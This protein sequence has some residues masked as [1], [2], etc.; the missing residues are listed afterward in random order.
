MTN[1]ETR[2][3]FSRAICIILALV[4]LLGIFPIAAP[5]TVVRAVTQSQ[6]NT[7]ARADYLYDITW[8]CQKTVS[9][10]KGK[11]TFYEGQ[12]YRIPYAWPVTAGKWVGYGVSVDEFLSATKDPES[13]FYTKQSYYTGNSGSYAPY[14]GNDCSTF[15]SWCWDLS[16]RQ[17]TQSITSV[18]GVSLLGA[19]TASNVNANLQLGDA[20]N[21]AGSHIVLVTD[22]TY[23]ADGS[24]ASVEITEQ[25]P[26]QLKRTVH[27][28]SSLVSAYGANYKIYRYSGTVSEPPE[29]GAD[30]NYYTVPTADISY[31]ARGD[32]VAWIQAVLKKIGYSLSVDG[33]F[34]SETQNALSLYQSQYGLLVTG[35]AD[36]ATRASLIGWWTDGRGVYKTTANL[37]M[38][39][40]DGTSHSII[41]T[42]PAGTE[43]AVIG[44]NASGSWANIVY[45]SVEGWVN[46][47]Y[48]SFVRKFNYTVNFNT[49]IPETMATESFK[50]GRA[51]SI[52]QPPANP[53]GDHF[54]GW[55]LL[56]LSDLS[57]YDGTGWAAEQ[58]SSKLF[59]AG[60]L[61][62]FDPAMLNGRWGDD[63]FYLCAVWKSVPLPTVSISPSE[64]GITDTG[65]AVFSAEATGEGLTY[66]WSCSDPDFYEYLSGV[67]TKEL[68]VSINEALEE[69]RTL[70]FT[71]TVTDR[72]G[73]RVE[74]DAACL[75]Y[76][77]SPLPEYI[78]GDVNGDCTVSAYDVNL[79]KRYVTGRYA[80]EEGSSTYLA[81]DINGDG[82]ITAT[83]VNLLIRIVAG[84]YVAV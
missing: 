60:E 9:A 65:S 46:L 23:N 24:L 28:V 75:F 52:P 82:V 27:T 64:L 42:I 10:W 71:C 77:V 66:L 51:Y 63:S 44:F 32:E 84:T 53:N 39:T 31:G 69:E 8:V 2:S 34:G 79:A 21:Y 50:Q 22:I 37:N 81:G 29:K 61:L 14:Y 55:Q 7:V 70:T 12:T 67:D 54:A 5:V 4:I 33:I 56:R 72:Y 25:T 26:P 36:E 80:I 58:G 18:S 74:S 62:V 47:G 19:V 57:W 15:V 38:R 59:A 41:T 6:L 3:R 13:E 43:V 45:N 40:G 11:N 68:T 17:T 78:M 48:L 16:S 1:I 76:T 20:L 83:D 73:Q 49:N 35:I 30:P